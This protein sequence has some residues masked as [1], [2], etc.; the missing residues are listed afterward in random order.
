MTPARFAFL[1]FTILTLT[2]VCAQPAAAQ[3]DGFGLG[4]ILGEPT[5]ISFKGWMDSRS[6]IDAGL[7]WSFLHETSFHVHADYLLHTSKLTER[8]DMP[9]YYG[10]GGRIKAGG[11]GSD[12]IGVRVVGGLAWYLRDAPIDIFV[13]I[14]PILDFA[15]STDF[16]VNGGLGARYFFR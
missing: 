2:A 4:L 1:A 11:R 13:E 8:A 14:A 3:R 7:A 12:R 6:A 16:Q 10:I 15:P 5:G 9:A